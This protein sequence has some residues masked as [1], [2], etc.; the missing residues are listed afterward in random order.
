[1]LWI[2]IKNRS[3]R[4][5][6]TFFVKILI[7]KKFSTTTLTLARHCQEI[8]HNKCGFFPAQLLRI[9]HSSES[10]EQGLGSRLAEEDDIF[11]WFSMAA[12]RAFS[13]I[14]SGLT[15]AVGRAFSAV[16]TTLVLYRSEFIFFILML[17][18]EFSDYFCI[19][20]LFDKMPTKHCL[21]AVCL[22]LSKYFL[23]QSPRKSKSSVVD[24]DSDLNWIHII[25][26]R[27][28]KAKLTD[29]N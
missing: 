26:N 9:R 20:N 1:M 24:P 11:L 2:R 29:K 15:G 12:S 25:K 4:G 8:P 13:L 10:G 17:L 14:D 3:P 16:S 18:K 28:K 21:Q 23:F 7:Q 6:C 27:G 22:T 19:T 5:Q